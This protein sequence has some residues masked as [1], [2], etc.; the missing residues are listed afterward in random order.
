MQYSYLNIPRQHHLSMDAINEIECIL[1]PFL[2]W[3]YAITIT[4]ISSKM[5]I[6][7]H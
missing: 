4:N 2:F 6:N 1:S 7:D 3:F 5:I